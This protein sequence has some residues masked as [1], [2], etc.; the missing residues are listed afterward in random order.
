MK[1]SC[2]ERHALREIAGHCGFDQPVD[3]A[4]D[5]LFRIVSLRPFHYGAGTLAVLV[6]HRGGN[7]KNF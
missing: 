6:H 5:R 3:L 1:S 2:L 7:K 4:L